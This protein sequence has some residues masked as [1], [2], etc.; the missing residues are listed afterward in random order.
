MEIDEKYQYFTFGIW[1]N[2]LVGYHKPE[3][4]H[5]FVYRITNIDSG[6]YYIGKKQ[7]VNGWKTYMSSSRPLL[8]EIER[9]GFDNY[10][11]EI[12]SLHTDELSMTIAERGLINSAKRLDEDLYNIN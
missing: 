9:E 10:K 3:R 11:F 6:K 1:E 2:D 7:Y 12:L 8:E 5:G 4:Y